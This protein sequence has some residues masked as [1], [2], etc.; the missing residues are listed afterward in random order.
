VSEPQ[1]Q[2]EQ[3]QSDQ[4]PS[5]APDRVAE[6]VEQWELREAVGG[7]RGIVDSGLASTVFLLVYVVDGRRLVPAVAAALAATVV[8]LVVRLVRHEPV[9]H[10]AGG[11]LVVGVSAAIALATGRASNFYILGILVQAS[12]AVAY[13]VSLAIG[14]PLLGVIVGPLLGEGFRWHSVPARRRA[15]FW[16]SCVW[17]VVFLVRIA[18]QLPLYLQDRVVSLG[19]AGLLLG[20]PLFAAAALA[21]WLILR[22]V[23]PAL[24]PDAG[25]G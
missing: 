17:F 22:R 2:R 24:S 11:V 14:W 23:P 20:W 15:Y 7:L 19:V 10:A 18:V 21:S 13:L 9:R 1:P 6:L 16:A 12:Y 8:L 3:Q 5:A 4:Q 25:A